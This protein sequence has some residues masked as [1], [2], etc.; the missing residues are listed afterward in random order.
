MAAQIIGL[1]YLHVPSAIYPSTM[2]IAQDLLIVGRYSSSDVSLPDGEVCFV[3][4]K[5][6]MAKLS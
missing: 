6:I 3:A 1:K 2:L 5:S 4:E